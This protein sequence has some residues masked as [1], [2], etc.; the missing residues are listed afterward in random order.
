MIEPGTAAPDFSL[1]DQDGDVVSLADLRGSRIVLVFYPSDFSPVCTDQL[2]VY[3][4][5]L[6]Q[7][8]AAGARLYGLSVDSAYCHKAFR[9]RLGVTIPLLSD[10]N[11]KGAVAREYGVYV[12]DY[13]VAA[14][15]L[16]MIGPDGTVEWAHHPPSPLEVPGVDL[17]REALAAAAGP[18]TA[19]SIGRN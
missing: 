6:A 15:A 1:P 10:F 13:G 4:E 19:D 8:E 11:P 17:I 18:K 14:R 7:L 9:D 12:E 5:S 2:S 16:V 3:Q